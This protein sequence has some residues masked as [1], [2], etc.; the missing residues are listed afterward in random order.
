MSVVKIKKEWV[1][2]ARLNPFLKVVA[3]DEEKALA[4]YELDRRLCA[5]LFQE[6][7]YIEVAL[8][9]S[10]TR[11]LEKAYGEDWYTKIEIGFDQRVR[12]NLSESWDSLPSRYTAKGT[13][14]NR[15]LGGR[16]IGASMFRTWTNMLDKGGLTGLQPP[17]EAADHD[18]IWTEEAILAV[19][20]G[21]RTVAKQ[22]QDYQTN[23]LTREWVYK[24]VFPIRQ[25]RNRI[26]HHESVVPRG[27]PIPGT[28]TRL[29]ARDCHNSCIDVAK[30]LDR[31]LA[32]YLE[33]LSIN[34]LLDEL[35]GFFIAE[36]TR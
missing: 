12:E 13:P 32:T 24:K 6:I 11:Y 17:F 31:D 28:E 8:R 14:R 18:R 30:M 5:A 34:S 21:A 33:S 19:F 26:G 9:N 29:T 4:L 7:A 16:L 1:S 35:D 10:M 20:R 22:D 25:I 3:N 2:E 23:G 27:V 15:K 36:D